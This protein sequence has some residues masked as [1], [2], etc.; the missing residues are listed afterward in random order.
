MI[1]PFPDIQ[2]SRNTWSLVPH[3]KVFE[4]PFTRS[5]QTVQLGPSR[6][7]ASLNFDRLNRTHAQRL[8]AF[9]AALNGVA[10]AFYL[11]DSARPQTHYHCG[12]PVVH[13]FEGGVLYTGG[14]LE[15]Q[16]VLHAGAYIGIHDE[17]KCLTRDVIS[18]EAGF[19]TLHFMPELRHIPEAQTP[20]EYH[21]PQ[22]VMRLRERTPQPQRGLGGWTSLRIDCVE[23]L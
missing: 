18:D 14:W 8:E 15:N 13:R 2:P 19:A 6:W 9:L 1:S 12:E 7:E 4:S 11:H 3:Q 21:Q 23:V 17:L 22:V 16:T 20:V 5:I 10:G